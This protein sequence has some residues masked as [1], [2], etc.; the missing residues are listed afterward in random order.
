[1]EIF[2]DDTVVQPDDNCGRGWLRLDDHP[3][4]G[5]DEFVEFFR[6][7]VRETEATVRFGAADAFG[8]RRSVDAISG[9]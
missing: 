3:R 7:P 6:V 8:E 1:M 9:D 4:S 2:E 5:A